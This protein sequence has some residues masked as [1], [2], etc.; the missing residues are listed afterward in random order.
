MRTTQNERVL[1]AVERL[2]DEIQRTNLSRQP[3]FAVGDRQEFFGSVLRWLRRAEMEE[4]RYQ[5]DSRPR[6][7]WLREFW[8][9]EPHLA[10]V[11]H[12]VT[13]ID[14]N[15]HW[16]LTGGRNQVSRFME[17]LQQAENGAGWRAYVGVQAMSYYAADVGA[18]TE[19][20]R[21]GRNGP[22][23]ALYHVDPARCRLTGKADRPLAYDKTK[24]PWRPEDF[25]RIASMASTDEEL[26]GLG[27]CAVSRVLELAKLMVGVYE[28]SLEKLG[29]RAPKGLLLLKG[30]G[31]EQWKQAMQ[32]REAALQGM[33]RDYYGAVAVLASMGVDDMDAK[34]V[35]LSQ[36]PDGFDLKTWTDLTMYGFALCFGYDPIEFWPVQAGS[37]GRGRETEIQH[38]KATGKGAAS[39]MRAHQD[40]LQ[41]RLPASLLFEYEQRDQTGLLLEAEVTQAWATVAKTLYEQGMGVLTRQQAMSVLAEQGVIPRE[42]TTLEEDAE[43]A[44]TGDMDLGAGEQ[45]EKERLLETEAVRRAIARF[46]DEPLVRVEWP[47]GRMTT[48]WRRGDEAMRRGWR[49]EKPIAREEM[50]AA[51]PAVRREDGE[52]VLFEGEDFS[53]TEADVDAAIRTARARVGDE[54][55]DLLEARPLT[56]EEMDALDGGQGA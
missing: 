30:I 23:R 37:L 4:P 45:D 5:A 41:M 27:F 28:H 26:N 9:H 39:F 48:L 21:E 13:A 14:Q 43:G 10:G 1:A 44:D 20:G 24:E 54:L 22:L 15:R 38:M 18:I 34:L 25:F 32:S 40:Q 11:L 12:S 42:W 6:D 55:G 52:G 53:V 50:R 2:G 7:A 29:S 17:I 56:D 35:A 3:R 8:R 19:V 16:T 47:S 31:E 46:A 33:E 51:L 49:V 36:L